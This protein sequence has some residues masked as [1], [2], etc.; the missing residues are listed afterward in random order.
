MNGLGVLNQQDIK[1]VWY[2]STLGNKMYHRVNKELVLNVSI[3]ETIK[4]IDKI[5]SL[6]L[7]SNLMYGLSVVYKLQVNYMLTELLFMRNKIK[8]QVAMANDNLLTNTKVVTSFLKDDPKFIIQE[9]VPDFDFDDEIE[10]GRNRELRIDHF[11]ADADI[12]FDLAL[13][14]EEDDVEYDLDLNLSDKNSIDRSLTVSDIDQFDLGVSQSDKNDTSDIISPPV[15]ESKSYKKRKHCLIIDDITTLL[16]ADYIRF[17]SNYNESMQKQQLLNERKLLTKHKEPL[18]RIEVGRKLI[19]PPY[20]S[21]DFDI[22]V[23]SLSGNEDPGFE[24][25][26]PEIDLS[27]IRSS[28]RSSITRIPVIDINVRNQEND[29]FLNYLQN[30]NKQ[31]LLFSEICPQRCSKELAAKSFLTILEL[32]T[33]GKTRID[34]PNS[35]ELLKS[36]DINV[37]IVEVN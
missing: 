22:M 32:T 26:F 10:L 30:F 9:L 11:E 4:V 35:S 33:N 19:R 1:T 20:E 23:D 3:P 17:K 2:L 28:A 14:P 13:V 24:L 7:L 25:S 16:D 36:T 15:P 29:R 8:R 37:A 21:S 18:N 27:E 34:T 31:E 12:S 6:V 5:D